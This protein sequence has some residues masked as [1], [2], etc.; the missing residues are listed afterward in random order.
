M[1]VAATVIPW[2]L[3]EEEGVGENDEV[4]TGLVGL[5]VTGVWVGE[6]VPDEEGELVWFED[7]EVVVG[8]P[9]DP[10]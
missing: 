7:G 5:F 10:G 6:R 1:T 8:T 3:L 9:V 2:I 4:C